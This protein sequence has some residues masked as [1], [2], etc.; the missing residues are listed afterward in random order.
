MTANGRNADGSWLR[1]QTPDSGAIGW[2]FANLLTK[3]GDVSSLS[4]VDASQTDVPFTPMQ[5][6]YF[7]TGVTQTNCEQAP[8]DGILIQTPEGVGQISLRANDVDIQLGSTA[9]LQ[10]QPN[11][12]MTVSVVEGKVTSPPT[13]RPS[14]FRRARR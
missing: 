5:A 11:A 2:V 10:A 7:S 4:V 3:D 13:A 14:T 1:I 6:F 8:Q 12:N 9:F